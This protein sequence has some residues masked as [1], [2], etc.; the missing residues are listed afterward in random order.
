MILSLFTIEHRLTINTDNPQLVQQILDLIKGEKASYELEKT[1]EKPTSNLI[2][3]LETLASNDTIRSIKD[4]LAWQQEIR[5]D[6]N[7]IG[8][9]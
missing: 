3:V 8:R 7:L 6:K 9:E 4:P 5:K 1:E 2:G